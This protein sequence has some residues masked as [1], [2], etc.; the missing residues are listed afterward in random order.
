[1]SH[2]SVTN[3]VLKNSIVIKRAEDLKSKRPELN[4]QL[5]G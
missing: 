5:Y 3:Q 2:E 1:M 4:S